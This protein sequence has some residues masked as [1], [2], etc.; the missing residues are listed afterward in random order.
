MKQFII[1]AFKIRFRQFLSFRFIDY[2][3]PNSDHV[4]SVIYIRTKSHKCHPVPRWKINQAKIDYVGQIWPSRQ[5][6]LDIFS[7]I[8]LA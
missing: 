6:R 1:L 2:T 4:L 8:K 3:N 5:I 7:K